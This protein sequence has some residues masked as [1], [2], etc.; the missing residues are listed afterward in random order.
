MVSDAAAQRGEVAK[1]ASQGFATVH[2][3]A[4]SITLSRKKPF[5]WVVAIVC[6]FI[7]IIGWIALIAMMIAAGRGAEVVEVRLNAA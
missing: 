5:N 4:Q 6:L 7:P 1:L 3:D 2:S